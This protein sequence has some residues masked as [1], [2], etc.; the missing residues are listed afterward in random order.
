MSGPTHSLE[1]VDGYGPARLRLGSQ[2]LRVLGLARVNH[3][4]VQIGPLLHRQVVPEV[5]RRHAAPP[6]RLEAPS[7]HLPLVN[8]VKQVPCH[9]RSEEHTSE[10]QSPYDLVCRLLLEKKKKN[11]IN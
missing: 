10:L 9:G 11:L 1:E 2:L 5:H 3:A 6:G 8:P 7:G 4:R